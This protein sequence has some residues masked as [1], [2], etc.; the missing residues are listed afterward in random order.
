MAKSRSFAISGATQHSTCYL[1]TVTSAK[2]RVTNL[3]SIGIDKQ[4]LPG[5]GSRP[6]RRTEVFL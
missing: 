4:W 2:T 1:Y 6:E 5:S 3:T